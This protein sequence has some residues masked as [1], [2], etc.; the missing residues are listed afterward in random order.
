M[1]AEIGILRMSLN[2]NGDS[3]ELYFG[4][5]LRVKKTNRI[6][7]ARRHCVPFLEFERNCFFHIDC[8][9]FSKSDRSV[10]ISAI[11]K[12]FCTAPWPVDSNFI[13]FRYH[14]PLSVLEES[15]RS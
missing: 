8:P 2:A 9:T 11:E 15:G 13:Y 4:V 12:I 14:T 5:I 3:K 10:H 1:P 6:E 7:V